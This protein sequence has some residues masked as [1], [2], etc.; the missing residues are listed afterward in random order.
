MSVV[1][2]FLGHRLWLP[3]FPQYKAV[4]CASTCLETI[5]FCSLG[6]CLDYLLRPY[7]GQSPRFNWW[8]SEVA[9]K[10]LGEFISVC[11]SS[12]GVLDTKF[13]WCLLLSIPYDS[14]VDREFQLDCSTCLT[15]VVTGALSNP[16][17]DIFAFWYLPSFNHFRALNFPLNGKRFCHLGDFEVCSDRLELFDWQQPRLY[18]GRGMHENQIALLG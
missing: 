9:W 16:R 10:E 2:S 1:C 11:C 12:R 17:F 3:C 6:H 13:H 18:I 15:V 8:N 14:E 7:L 4:G 5:N